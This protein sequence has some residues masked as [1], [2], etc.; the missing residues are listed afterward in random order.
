MDAVNNEVIENT[1]LNTLNINV[2]KLDKKIP[3]ATALIYVNQYRA[4]NQNLEK[5]NDMLT[6]NTRC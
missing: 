4:G 5:K 3:D 2:N 6:K 1:K